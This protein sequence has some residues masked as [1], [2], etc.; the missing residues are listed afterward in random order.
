LPAALVVSHGPGLLAA[1]FAADVLGNWGEPR[2]AEEVVV[3]A[4]EERQVGWV[5]L[6]EKA[7]LEPWRGLAELAGRKWIHGDIA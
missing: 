3:A 6:V 2:I 4:G 7:V 1:N 5:E